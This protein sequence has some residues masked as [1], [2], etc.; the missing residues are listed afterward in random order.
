MLYTQTL[1]TAL[2]AYRRRCVV[3]KATT[4]KNRRRERRLGALEYAINE[5]R[6]RFTMPWSVEKHAI[7]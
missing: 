1:E 4:T 7:H 2:L 3:T 5:A 6:T